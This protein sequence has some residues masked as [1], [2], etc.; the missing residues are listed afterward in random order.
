MAI[1]DT[2]LTVGTIPTLV[3]NPGVDQPATDVRW[4]DIHNTSA[5]TVYFGGVN[6]TTTTGRPVVTNADWSATLAAGDVLYAV[7]AAGTAVINLLRSRS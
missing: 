3:A 2:T 1:V 4:V 6:V 5:V 7:V